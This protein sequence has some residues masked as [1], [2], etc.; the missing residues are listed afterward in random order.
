M[1]NKIR[2]WPRLKAEVIGRN[3]GWD[4]AYVEMDKEGTRAELGLDYNI[5]VLPCEKYA[6]AH[7]MQATRA[8]RCATDPHKA[9]DTMCGH[10]ILLART[11]RAGGI[12]AWTPFYCFG[13]AKEFW[14]RV[15]RWDKAVRDA[16]EGPQTGEIGPQTVEEVGRGG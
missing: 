8:V 13:C 5:V 15:K 2:G 14:N 10:P 7:R 12:Y 1:T 4:R 16:R 11:I 3:Y 6:K 9:R